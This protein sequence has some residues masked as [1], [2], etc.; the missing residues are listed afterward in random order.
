[1]VPG[2]HRTMHADA[3]QIREI[4]AD[5]PIECTVVLRRRG[6]APDPATGEILTRQELA[7]RYG[8]DPADVALLTK[9]VTDAGAA[10]ESVDVTS[11]R[12]K[13]SGPASVLAA[14]FG[15]TLK[16]ASVPEL[17]GGS[18]DAASSMTQIRYR[19]GELSVPAALDGVVTAVLGL[20]TRP[21]GRPHF[22]PGA[23]GPHK[24][25]STSYT[26][27]QLARIYQMPDDADGTGQ[28]IA[29]IEL[30]GGFSE[31]DLKTYF[32]SLGVTMPEVVAVGVDGATNSPGGGAD[33][34]DGE[35]MLDIEVAGAIAPGSSIKVYFAP[36]TDAG[37]LDAVVEAAQADPTPAAISISWGASESEWTAQARK[38]MDDAF[39]DAATLGVTVTAAAGDDGSN[40]R[41]GDGKAHADFPA[42]SP[43]AL[44]CGGTSLDADPDTGEVSSE[45][46]WNNGASGGATGGGVSADFALP[47]WQGAAGVPA[48]PNGQHGRGV[49]DVAGVADPQ[50]GYQVRVDGKN[51]VFGG[52]SAVAPLWAALIARLV[53]SLG[54]PLG[55]LQPSIYPVSAGAGSGSGSSHGKHA[56]HKSHPPHDESAPPGFRDVTSGNNG[57]FTAGPGWD[58]CTGLGVP[59]GTDLLAA[60]KTSAGSG[61]GSA[62][63]GQHHGGPAS[64]GSGSGGSG[65]GGSASGG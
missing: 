12:V 60:L 25:T 23:V 46:V 49:P 58:A 26:P 35:V 1:M 37:F 19:S 4:P 54:R 15:T 20:D 57:A 18:G 8:A 52:T 62:S 42:S 59:V 24:A 44:G 11:R 40:D 47:S 55:L 10:V 7:D 45:T 29:I 5:E 31:D 36:N 61:G 17:P 56:T 33:G 2:S 53:Q 43:H 50:T 39:A 41:V 65:S 22:R 9:T 13:V 38:S 34:P 63:T 30:G 6:D 51:M 64:G 16:Q 27:V 28:V 32:G 3:A 48:R 21:Q 14:L